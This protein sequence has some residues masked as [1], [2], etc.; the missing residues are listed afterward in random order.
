MPSMVL[1]DISPRLLAR[2]QAGQ[3][4]GEEV[5]HKQ[6]IQ[7]TRSVPEQGKTVKNPSDESLSPSYCALAGPDFSCCDCLAG[8][9]HTGIGNALLD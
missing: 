9:S 1:F 5:T 4:G 6:I 8:R 2:L 7:T 3:S